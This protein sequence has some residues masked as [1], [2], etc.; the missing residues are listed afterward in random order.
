LNIVGAWVVPVIIGLILIFGLAQGVKPFDCFLQG[1]SDGLTALIKIIPSLIGLITAVEMF[2]ASG[3]LDL[4]N[5]ALSPVANFLQ[6]PS[7]VMPLALLRPISGG[8]TI[9]LLDRI[10]NAVGPDSTAGR[11]ASVM[12]GS[13]ETTFYTMAVY[14]GS[15]GITRTR[16]TLI[17]AL[18]G[19]FAAMVISAAVV[20][21]LF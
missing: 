3:A 13:S 10:L 11:T 21:L 12:C 7:E 5:Y 19:D 9:A 15:C 14:Y 6:I 8:G 20:R 17:A 1:A 18:A 2:K 4:L 16:Y